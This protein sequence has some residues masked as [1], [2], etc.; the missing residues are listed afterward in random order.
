MLDNLFSNIFTIFFRGSDVCLVRF[1]S[2]SMR[3]FWFQVQDFNISNIFYKIQNLK[4][5]NGKMKAVVSFLP[6]NLK[7][8][9]PFLDCLSW[10]FVA[11]WVVSQFVYS[12]NKFFL[13]PFWKFMFYVVP[14]QRFWNPIVP[15][16]FFLLF[17]VWL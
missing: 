7:L 6:R 1:D 2:Y 14:F 10:S 9:G 11:N 15:W 12:V 17:Y 5:R 16:N 4:S 13:A 3:D 8:H